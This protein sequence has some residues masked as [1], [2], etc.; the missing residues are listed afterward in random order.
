V[1]DTLL[2]AESESLGQNVRV[3]AI[4]GTDGVFLQPPECSRRD[5]AHRDAVVVPL[6]DVEVL[7]AEGIPQT[8]EDIEAESVGR[9]V[10]DRR[11]V[12]AQILGGYVIDARIFK[13]DA[14]SL[15]EA[16]DVV[17][18]RP[19]EEVEIGSRPGPCKPSATAPNTAYS[20]RCSLNARKIARSRCSSRFRDSFIPRRHLRSEYTTS[21]S[22]GSRSRFVD[23][24]GKVPRRLPI[25]E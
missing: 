6:L 9:L 14:K 21:W 12:P 4:C 3:E 22:V 1:T 2:L 23:A 5:D 17:C 24:A 19:Y 16:S 15:L 18:G 13:D 25:R 8:R 11:I 10:A 7:V 20:T